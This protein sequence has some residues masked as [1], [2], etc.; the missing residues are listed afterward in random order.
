MAPVPPLE[1]TRTL[2]AEKHALRENAVTLSAGKQFL[3][4]K[5]A[6]IKKSL[7]ESNFYC[8]KTKQQS[9]P[10]SNFYDCQKATHVGRECSDIHTD[11]QKGSIARDIPNQ[12]FTM[13]P[14]GLW[15]PDK[16]LW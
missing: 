9:L 1:L 4:P 11:C 10:Q 7:P 5:N 15:D 13:K 14:W 12:Q 2:A 3:L 8:R 6:A 16:Y